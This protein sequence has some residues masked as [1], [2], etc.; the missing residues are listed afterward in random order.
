[1]RTVL[2][3]IHERLAFVVIAQAAAEVKDDIVVVQGE[4]AEEFL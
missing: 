4:G 1:M 3:S 2:H